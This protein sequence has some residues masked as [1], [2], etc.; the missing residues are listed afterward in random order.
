[1]HKKKL[2]MAAWE[3][4]YAATGFGTRVGGLG[5]VMQELP[6]A[7]ARNA[8]KQGKNLEIEVLSPCFHWY[9]RSRLHYD[10][11]LWVPHFNLDFDVFSQVL[12]DSQGYNLKHIYFWN[13]AILGNLGNPQHPQS[14]YPQNSWDALRIYARVSA[15]I[16]TYLTVTGCYALHLHDYHMGL[17]PFYLDYP[18][19]GMPATLFTIHNASY[20]G[21][22]EIWHDPGPVMY[23]V[24]MPLDC[25]YRYFQ[26]WGNWNTM[27][28]VLIRMPEINGVVTTV[29]EGYARELH[30]SEDDIRRLAADEDCPAQ[31][32]FVPNNYLSELAWANP[33][34]INN[35]LDALNR[36]ENN[37]L[38]RAQT[39][40]SMQANRHAPL[41]HDPVVQERMLNFDHNYSLDDLRNRERLRELLHLECFHRLPEEHDIV[42]CTIGRL[43]EQKNLQVLLGVMEPMVQR[44][45]NVG[46]AI[47]ASADNSPYSR[48]LAEHFARAAQ[49]PNIYFFEG[50]N[51]PLARLILAGSNF[52]LIPSSFE[53]CGLIDYEAALLGNV[54]IVRKTGGLVKTFPY[55]LGYSWYE[56]DDP[57]GEA[58]AIARVS[59]QAID[60]YLH[61]NHIYQQ[62]VHGCMALDTSWEL[63][64][65]KYFALL[66]I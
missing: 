55:A 33:L 2:T 32:V 1:M 38:F 64:V 46:F 63:S 5:L 36:P 41:F 37:R 19:L 43:V 17:I 15:A 10:G 31:N 22:M 35:G 40:R 16:A 54:P 42:F 47:I 30:W 48:R 28:G 60:E 12:P 29:S 11:S 45:P 34:G 8:Q 58:H 59:E 13:E 24:A 27:K 53:P 26:Y 7:M 23:E 52:C 50:F 44:Y 25:Y 61:H 20:Q 4:G 49:H 65:D 18:A 3:T 21:Q 9:D 6:L 56:R 66:R 62:R 51:E 14:I 57:W 39:L